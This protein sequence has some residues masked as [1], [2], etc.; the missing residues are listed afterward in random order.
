MRGS[1]AQSGHHPDPDTRPHEGPLRSDLDRGDTVKARGWST[2]GVGKIPPGGVDIDD[3][4]DWPNVQIGRV[5]DTLRTRGGQS[6]LYWEIL[7]IRPGRVKFR[8]Y[9]HIRRIG[10]V[11]ETYW[12]EP[13]AVP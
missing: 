10:R 1:P 4:S 9:G 2:S 11:D 6:N 13:Y 8:Q 12:V 7:E 3:H 5:G